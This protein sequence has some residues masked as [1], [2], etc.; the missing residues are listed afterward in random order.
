[1]ENAAPDALPH[2]RSWSALALATALF[3]L[4]FAVANRFQLTH[5]VLYRAAAND[6]ASATGNFLG[7]AIQALALLAAI[8]L[9]GRKLFVSAMV[10][11][12]AS[13]LINLGYGQTVND[14][15]GVGTMAWMAAETR[16]AGN[17]AG[18]FAGPL[19]LAAAQT[20]L[21]VTLLIAARVA[22]RRGGW[23]SR[24]W[25]AGAAGLAL[26]VTPSLLAA[27]ADEPA[28]A[29][30]NVYS[31]G[32]E[33]ALA[34]PPPPRPPV[35]LVPTVRGTPRA[36]VWLVD[37]SVAYRQ[38]HE[39]LA[40]RL[41]QVAHVDFGMAASLGHCS[42]PANLALRSGVDVRRAG[43]ML[44]LRR[45]PS[46]WGYARKAGYRT[47]LIDGQTRG[48]PQNLL[49]A[50][51]R[52]LIDEVVSAAGGMDTDLEIAGR[53]NRTLRGGQRTFVYV[54]LRGVHFQYRDHFP[55]GL[56]PPDSPILLQYRT[57]LEYSKGRF[58]DRL[59][60]GVD[61]DSVAV[62]YTSDHGQNLAPGAVP[63]CSASPAPA[64][65]QVP[66]LAF[67][68]ERL[69]AAYTDT[70][71]SGHAA[72]QIFPATLAWMGYDATTVQR[73]YDNDLSGLPARYVR[74]DRDVVPLRAGDPAGVIVE[75]GF[76]GAAL[77]A[78][79]ADRGD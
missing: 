64:E 21:A 8:A 62:V 30:R 50:P 28:S 56:I 59:L 42:A 18:E 78:K 54:V 4:G 75:A 67:L 19:L 35:E 46:I 31:L 41:A 38:F 3:A 51:E 2:R 47:V 71:R 45:T 16:Q 10:L 36:I 55:A 17:A 20:V 57:A 23:G 37:E 7:L 24:G 29:E 34:A 15:I 66:L 58:F 68:P 76:P 12:F 5:G 6:W 65:L 52:A 44:D 49:L 61:R 73:Q 63:H 22:L 27:A 79:A 74:F 70:P 40:P 77:A 14:V 25:A 33:I 53:L 26:L 39:L 48:Q 9:L 60:E 69:A 11:A 32:A 72:S 43:P 13:I 1:M